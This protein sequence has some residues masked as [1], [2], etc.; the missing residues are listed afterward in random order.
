M[1]HAQV[2]STMNLMMLRIVHDWPPQES[3]TRLPS[4]S[5]LMSPENLGV[6]SQYFLDHWSDVSG[7]VTL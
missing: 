3:C 4:Q 1:C 7:E 2:Q 6:Q 5:R